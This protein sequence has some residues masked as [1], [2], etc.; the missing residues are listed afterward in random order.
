MQIISTYRLQFHKGFTFAHAAE[1]VPYLSNLGI[2]HV[3]ASPYLK[4][5]AG[6]THGYDVI[7][8]KLLNPELGSQDDYRAW[9]NALKR[10]GMSHI[11]DTVPN[12]MGVETNDNPLWNEILAGGTQSEY[13]DYFDIDWTGIGARP[14]SEGKVLLP[15]LGEPCAHAIAAGKISVKEF[16][17]R[18]FICYGERRFPIDPATNLNQSLSDIVDA[19]HYRLSFWRVA[20]DEINYRRFFDISGL[21]ALQMQH[22]NVF[23]EAHEFTFSLI[24][25][26]SIDGLRV[27]HPDGLL[28]PQEYFNRLQIKYRQSCPQ[29]AANEPKLY[30]SVEKILNGDERLC[31]D[32]DVAGTSGYDFLCV[33]N[34]LFVDS[35]NESAVTDAY[36]RFIGAAPSYQD[37]VYLEKCRVLDRSMYSE[38]ISLTR[39]LDKLAQADISSRDFTRR[40]LHQA[41]RAVIACFPVYRSYVARS[42]VSEFDQQVVKQAVT[43]AAARNRDLAGDVLNFIRDSVLLIYPVG[44]SVR[45]LQ[46]EFAQRFQQLTSP[47]NAKGIEDSTFYIYN[48]LTSLNEVGGDPS[49]FG[50][51]IE[52]V[53]DYFSDRQANWPLAL[54]SLSTHDTKRS[55]DVRARINALSEVPGKW[56]ESLDAWASLEL[57]EMKIIHRNDLTLLFQTLIGAW[58]MGQLEEPE[59][60]VFV[61]R[62]TAYLQKA[63]R[64]AKQ[65]TNWVDPDL[66]YEAA[67]ARLIERLVDPTAGRAFHASFVPLQQQVSRL[68][69]INSLSQTVLRLTAPG[70][71]DTYQGT[72]IWDL[73]LVDPDNRRPVDY[74]SRSQILDGLSTDQIPE[75]VN[76]MSDGRIKLWITH[77][78]L[79]LRKKASALFL[80]GAYIPLAVQ[81]TQIK[82]VF[83]FARHFENQWL[84]VLV[85]R[86]VASLSTDHGW[87]NQDWGNTRLMLPPQCPAGEFTNV[88]SPAHSAVPDADRMIVV[89]QLLKHF[90]GAVLLARAE[91]GMR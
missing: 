49:R 89:G 48:R 9:V 52:Q 34:E 69:L 77:Q 64:E 57:P 26:G 91:A 83:A 21:A 15:V 24:A 68:G 4:A 53:H 1:I 46:L 58:P 28:D 25:D 75:M 41:L 23:D 86:L 32:W 50:R 56:R 37:Q 65:R 87:G 40:Q 73:S 42:R 8:H 30:V 11:L 3:Y 81:G 85:P 19:Q 14:E 38:M 54:S 63:L 55:E 61:K 45:D 2:T 31:S 29:R 22:Q 67:M 59:R 39:Q 60:P 66:D 13:R 10:H 16:D 76:S 36:T 79:Q 44:D 90:P 43:Q 74:H 88:L 84:I 51:S 70:I 33:V 80:Q 20:A 71:C 5:A 47:V 82:S 35:D 12:H 62:I 72:E 17:G 27:D 18:H 6:S 7:N 78:L